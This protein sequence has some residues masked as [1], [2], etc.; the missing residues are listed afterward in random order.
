MKRR[1]KNPPHITTVRLMNKFH[2]SGG[3]YYMDP[4]DTKMLAR[5]KKDLADARREEPNFG[6]H[7][8]TRGTHATWH[9]WVGMN[10]SKKSRYRH[11][12]QRKFRTIKI[13][14]L[15]ILTRKKY[16]KLLRI[17]RSRRQRRNCC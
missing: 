14:R 7:L 4:D 5:I 9:R 11:S 13:D 15:G 3:E 8:E 2:E 6:W 16:A 12:R 10:P 1:R 17:T